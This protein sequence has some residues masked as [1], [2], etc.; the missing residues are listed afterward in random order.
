MKI[1]PVIS[2]NKNPENQSDELSGQKPMLIKL[3]CATNRYPAFQEDI[4]LDK[5]PAV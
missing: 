3:F 4:L 1:S 5:F 2:L